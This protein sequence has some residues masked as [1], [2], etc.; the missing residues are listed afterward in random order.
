MAGTESK[1]RE[2]FAPTRGDWSPRDDFPKVRS[3]GLKRVWV[4]AETDGNDKK[5]SKPVGFAVTTP[6]G[7]WYL[8]FGHKAGGNLDESAVKR[9]AQDEL[10]DVTVANIN[11]GFDA[12]VTLNWGVDL[13]RQGCVLHD[14]AHAAALINENRYKGVNLD[15]LGH[16]T[17]GRGKVECPVPP[18]DIHQ[19]HSSLIGKY[20]IGDSELAK[21]VDEAQRPAIAKDSLERV[22]ALEDELI[23]ANNHMERNGMRLD[24]PKLDRWIEEASAEYAECMMNIWLQ[25]RVKMRPNVVGDWGQLFDAVGLKR[26]ETGEEKTR[27]V[28]GEDVFAGMQE[29]YTDDFLKKVDHPL[30]KDA[31]RM[32]R[33][34]S[35]KSKYLEKYRKAQRDG[36]LPFNLYQLRAAEEDYGTVVGRYSSANVNIQQ[37]FKVENQ[38]KRFGDSFIIRELMVCDPGEEMFAVDGSQLQFRLFAHYS[39]DANLIAAYQSDL[40]L[41]PGEKPVDFHDLVARLFSLDRQ[42][43]KHNNFAMVLGMGREKLAN[44]LGLSCTCRDA[45]HWA[46]ARVTKGCPSVSAEERKQYLF[47]MNE[48]HA[49]NCPARKSNDLA[50]RYEREFPAAKRLMKEISKTAEERG[51][52]ATLL[53]RRRRYKEGDKFYSAFAGLLQGSEADMVKSK[54]NTLYKNRGYFGIL[55]CPVHDEVVGD[56]HPTPEAHARFKELCEVREIPLRVP[57]IWNAG[58]GPNWRACK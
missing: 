34:S 2:L 22:E 21:D 10:R 50:D 40:Y 44:R 29:S 58:F 18:Q 56:I 14:V 15:E 42:A 23:W 12:E 17:V 36:I 3:A 43:A 31:L 55:R 35:L 45:K 48:N 28:N 6:A 8:P 11:T 49:A 16:E 37:V 9:W 20:A 4:D 52:I 53:G 19:V 1:Q 46:M 30:V 7:S 13:E 33:I 32:R 54:I 25:T 26:N 5:K 57:M 27:K 39:R 51:W 38:V 47:G 24:M 41:K